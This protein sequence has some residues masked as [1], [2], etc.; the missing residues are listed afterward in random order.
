[1]ELA[2]TIQLLIVEKEK[3]ER[4]IAELEKLLRSGVVGSAAAGRRGRKSMGADERRE[5]SQRIKKYWANRRQ[6]AGVPDR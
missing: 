4:T 1:M 5:V 3:I 6:T 2:K